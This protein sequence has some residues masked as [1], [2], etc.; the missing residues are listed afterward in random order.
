[1]LRSAQQ[2]KYFQ[3][4][5]WT[6]YFGLCGVSAIFM[7]GVLEKYLSRKTSF[8]QSERPIKELPSVLL[9]FSNSIE[10]L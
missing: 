10:A 5:E 4:I 7:N 2:D 8:T 6:L 3:V 9:C 1:M